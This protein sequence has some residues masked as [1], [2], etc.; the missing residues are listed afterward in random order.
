MGYYNIFL[1]LLKITITIKKSIW[2]SGRVYNTD[3][4]GVCSSALLGRG[5]GGSQIEAPYHIQAVGAATG[6]AS[7]CIPFRSLCTCGVLRK[8]FYY[9]TCK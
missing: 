4:T 2:K 3:D 8:V 9:L 1:I 6:C 5:S 7:R